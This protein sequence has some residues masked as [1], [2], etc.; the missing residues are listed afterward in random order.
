MLFIIG[1]GNPGRRYAGTRHNIGF[2]VVDA[3]AKKHQL[4]VKTLHHRSLMGKGSVLGHKVFLV[5]PLTYMN[6]SGECVRRVRDYYKIDEKSELLVVCDD[7]ALPPGQI[8][9][10]K[11]GSDGGHKG[12]RSIIGCLGH[13]EFLRMR[14]GVGEKPAGE[15][16][17]E[18]VLGQFAA[19]DAQ[20]M[21]EAT[22]NAVAAIECIL[23][24]GADSAMN[25]FNA[26]REGLA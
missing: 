11:K 15:E 13:N 26:R 23:E 1:L 3:L 9:I 25:K 5:K 20:V 17:I 14:I 16:L 19:D 10:R 2:D 8:R 6:L 4:R 22:G 18:H 7:I 24:E 21:R 12:L